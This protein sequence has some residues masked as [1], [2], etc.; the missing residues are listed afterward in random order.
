MR[1]F[2]V[3][4]RKNPDFCSHTT[5]DIYDFQKVAH[6]LAENLDEVFELTNHIDHD[7]TKNEN[8]FVNPHLINQPRSTSVGDLIFDTENGVFYQVDPVGFGKDFL[9]KR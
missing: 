3:L 4:H 1:K 7:W 2:E 8:V 6:V 9:L 5:V